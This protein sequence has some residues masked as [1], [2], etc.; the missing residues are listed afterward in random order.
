MNIQGKYVQ[1][2][3]NIRDQDRSEYDIKYTREN[4]EKKSHAY[5]MNGK[6]DAIL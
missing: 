4:L 1:I 3:R 2:F 6:N 5:D